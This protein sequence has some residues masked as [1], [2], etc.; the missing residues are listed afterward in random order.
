T[1]SLMTHCYNPYTSI[2]QCHIQEQQ[3]RSSQGTVL[4]NNDGENKIRIRMRQY[5][6][7]HTVPQ[8]LSKHLSSGNRYF[9]VIRLVILVVLKG[10][11]FSVNLLA[12]KKTIQS[13]DISRFSRTGKNNQQ[14]QKSPTYAHSSDLLKTDSSDQQQEH[15]YA[16]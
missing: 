14:Q 3:H 16:K 9:C 15:A 4:F 2:H 10:S 1:E 13:T 7:L 8:S 5:I 12:L 11:S 6:P